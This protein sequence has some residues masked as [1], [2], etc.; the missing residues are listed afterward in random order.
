[1]NDAGQFYT[2]RVLKD[3]KEKDA[4]H[5][6]WVKAWIATLTELQ[7]YVKKNH[8]TGLTWNPQGAAAAAPAGG[9]GGPPPPPGPPP[10]V[11]ASSGPN[12][13]AARGALMD[14]LNRGADVTKGLRKVDKSEMTHKNPELRAG[15][16]V[17]AEM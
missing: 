11:A 3:W 2:N 13:A 5:V 7:G 10:P 17:K 6:A 16:V 4:N 9:A 8:T 15:S 1:M 12:P 14:S